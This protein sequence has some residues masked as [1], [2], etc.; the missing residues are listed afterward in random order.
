MAKRNPSKRRRRR[1]ILPSRLIFRGIDHGG[2]YH[3]VESYFRL[4]EEGQIIFPPDSFRTID[5]IEVKKR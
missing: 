2:G 5:E 1:R 3:R 4:R